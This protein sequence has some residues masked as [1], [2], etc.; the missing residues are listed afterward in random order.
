MP[1]CAREGCQT[2]ASVRARY[3]T[4]DET[5]DYCEDH[6]AVLRATEHLRIEKRGRVS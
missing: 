6:W 1:E 4:T 5:R 3:P 2:P